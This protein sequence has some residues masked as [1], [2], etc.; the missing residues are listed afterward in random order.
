MPSA[1]QYPHNHPYVLPVRYDNGGDYVVYELPQDTAAKHL[2]RTVRQVDPMMP[3]TPAAPVAPMESPMAPVFAPLANLIQNPLAPLAP[4]LNGGATDGQSGILAPNAAAGQIAERFRSA[5]TALRERIG[6]LSS[7]GNGGSETVGSTLNVS[8]LKDKFSSIADPLMSQASK[9]I[10]SFRDMASN[11]RSKRDVSDMRMP[12]LRVKEFDAS[13][14]SERY[15]KYLTQ[16]VELKTPEKQEVQLKEM[17]KAMRCH[18]CGSKLTES[19]CKRCGAYQPQYVEFVEGKQVSYYPGAAQ[20]MKNDEKKSMESPRYVFDRYG[21]RYLENNGNLRLIAPQYQEAVVGD[22]P[23]FA[24]LAN[25]L[26]ENREVIQQLNQDG[27]RMIPQPVDAIAGFTKLIR[28]L[29]RGRNADADRANRNEKRSTHA[30]EK[31]P[32]ERKDEKTSPRSMY[33]VVPMQYDGQDGKLVVR[34]Y[35]APEEEAKK[36][37]ER[38]EQNVQENGETVMNEKS[39]P[40][41]TKYTQNN[42][43]FEILT[44]DDYKTSSD[45]DI[46]RVI[47]HLHGKQQ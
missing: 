19:T 27:E 44:F 36:L 5:T 15:S 13:R 8:A 26:S 14:D 25:I 29:A 37:A 34:V 17:E 40:N 46:R 4:L 10:D 2:H 33:Q 30:V 18:S 9:M 23:N 16:R 31:R 7:G 12:M 47:E 38:T 43:E 45:E 39:Q 1:A 35:A 42:K 6:R 41:V 24:G 22:Q 21:H 28:Q 11:M 32:I 20:E 3:I